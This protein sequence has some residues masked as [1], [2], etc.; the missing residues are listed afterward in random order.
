MI[1]FDVQETCLDQGKFLEECIL[2]VKLHKTS[3]KV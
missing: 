2:P 3:D 1:S